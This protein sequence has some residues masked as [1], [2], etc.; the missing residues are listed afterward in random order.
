MRRTTISVSRLHSA[1]AG[2]AA[3]IAGLSLAPATGQEPAPVNIEVSRCVELTSPG[4]RLDCF[5][6][7]V[8]AAKRAAAAEAAARAP[9][10]APPPVAPA[11]RPVSPPAQPVAPVARPAPTAAPAPASAAPPARQ[12]TLPPPPTVDE[13]RASR[14][15]EREARETQEDARVEDP[16]LRITG[17]VAALR[18]TVPN[19]YLITLDNGQVWRQMRPKVFPIREGQQVEVYPTKWGTAFRLEVA[20]LNGYIQVERVR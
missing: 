16:A 4:Q 6:R 19:S 14:R 1:A 12:V 20:D 9:E 3:L 18:E 15:E 11:A 13:R 2:V 8:E 7:E 17:K 5:E 10:P